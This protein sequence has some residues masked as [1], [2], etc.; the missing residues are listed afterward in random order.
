MRLLHSMC[1]QPAPRTRNPVWGS[2]CFG[3]V[4]KQQHPFSHVMISSG[5]CLTMFWVP[6]F[7]RCGAGA[8]LQDGIYTIQVANRDDAQG[9]N[10][11]YLA[12][13]PDHASIRP[14][15]MSSTA[16]KPMKWELRSL[17]RDRYTLAT[18]DRPQNISAKLSYS[19]SCGSTSVLVRNADRRSW[20]LVAV[21]VERGLYRIVTGNKK[22]CEKPVL[23]RLA[24]RAAGSDGGSCSKDRDLSLKPV[25]RDTFGLIWRLTW[26]AEIIPV[27][28]PIDNTTTTPS[29]IPTVEVKAPGLAVTIL[30]IGFSPETFGEQERTAT[31]ES[32][33]AGSS[34][35]RDK[36]SCTIDDVRPLGSS[37]RRLLQSGVEV[38]ATLQFQVEYATELEEAEQAAS[39]LEEVLED[40]EAG[41]Q[42]FE[43]LT[44]A[45]DVVIKGSE[46][47][48]E[49]VEVPVQPPPTPE[50]TSTVDPEA[51][52]TPTPSATPTVTPTPTPT[53]T[54][55]GT[56]APDET[57]TPAL[58]DDP[59][60]T[61]P[62]TQTPPPFFGGTDPPI[63]ITD[64]PEPVEAAYPTVPCGDTV[65]VSW[66]APAVGYVETYSVECVPDSGSPL[67]LPEVSNSLSS[68]E[69]GPLVPGR[70]Y[71]C[72]VTATNAAGSSQP[73]QSTAFRTG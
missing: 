16:E 34:Y 35:P 52:A 58:T 31:C 48:T 60:E 7:F 49:T 6:C 12:Y 44:D 64:A 59:I 9:C 15:L 46:T 26:E 27:S 28:D 54:P 62:P 43:G 24:P 63:T 57:D 51:T 1:P 66:Q 2:A 71:R 50:P 68:V 5:V 30:L 73:G 3:V 72:S 11:M 42:L 13:R 45:E 8:Q 25:S 19:P 32:L 70:E 10:D 40:P 69:V 14:F 53:P 47:V 36:M 67:R 21:D 39:E 38:D 29:P 37:K 56:G 41:P 20:L 22:D 17:G 23:G 61:I 18:A 65:E 4:F 55:T 33:I